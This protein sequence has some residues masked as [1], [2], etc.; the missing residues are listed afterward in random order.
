[1]VDSFPEKDDSTLLVNA[2]LSMSVYGVHW[3]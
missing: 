1:M 3:E 2:V